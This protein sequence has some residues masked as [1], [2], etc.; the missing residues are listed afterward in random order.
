VRTT[1]PG[2]WTEGSSCDPYD[3]ID[4]HES[5]L[6]GELDGPAKQVTDR[7]LVTAIGQGREPTACMSPE[8]AGEDG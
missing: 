6:S 3:P 5:S 4:I 1:D 2:S 8:Q 7:T